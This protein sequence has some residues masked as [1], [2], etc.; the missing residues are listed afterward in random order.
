MKKIIPIMII[1]IF[2]LSSFGA[3]ATQ[4]EVKIEKTRGTHT[5]FGEYG[6]ATWCGYCKYAHGGLKE[7]YQEGNLDFHFVSLVDDVNTIAEARIDEYNIGGFPTVWWDGGYDVDVGSGSIPGAKSTYTASINSCVTREVEDIDIDL[8]AT[9]LGGT[10][11]SIDIT[12]TNN[13][14]ETYGGHVRVYITE[15]LSSMGWIDTAGNPY[16]FAFLD[17]GFNQTLSISSGGSWTDSTTW[18]GETNGFST[19]SEDNL[20]IFAAVFNDEWHQGYSYPPN[21]RP[22]DAYYVDESAAYRI[23]SNRAPNTPSNPNPYDGST[24]VDIKA[25]LSW[26]GTDPDWFDFLTY[27]IYFGT[28]NP[29]PL[30]ESDYEDQTYTPGTLEYETT[31]YWKIVTNDP[32]GE[33]AE[34]PVWDFTAESNDAPS[35]PVINGPPKGV[36]GNDYSYT[37]ESTDSDDY[38]VYYYIDWGDGTYEDWNGPYSSGKIFRISHSWDEESVFTIRAKAKD[39]FDEESSWT[40]FEIEIP[41]S[42]NTHNMLFDKIQELFPNAFQI[43][44]QILGL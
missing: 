3:I 14:A 11:I 43:L 40:E 1:G 7:L 20:M 37:F 29:P 27:D 16:A 9:W 41:R 35:A 30:V 17:W 22:F 5:A 44:R 8:S 12:V 31:Y 24:S 21:Q 36:P 15:I 6:T 26:K 10:E 42:R 18:D 33:S 34:G 19:V 4:N 13:E 39:V 25:E 23:G 2:F 28:T 32:Y 38:D